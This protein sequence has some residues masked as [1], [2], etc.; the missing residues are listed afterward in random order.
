MRNRQL[1]HPGNPAGIVTI[2]AGGGTLVPQLGQHALTLIDCADQALYQAKRSGRNRACARWPG[3]TGE[4][5][6]QDS[7]ALIT[8]KS[9]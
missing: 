4:I 7:I 8:A 3:T 2:S 9:A 5:E 6:E 1:P